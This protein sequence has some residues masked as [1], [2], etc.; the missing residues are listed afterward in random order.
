LGYKVLA[1]PR[2]LTLP[3]QE[4]RLHLKI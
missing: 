3:M 4:L 2:Q 1:N